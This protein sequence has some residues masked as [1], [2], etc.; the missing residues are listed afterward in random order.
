MARIV[1]VN[2]PNQQHAAI[3]LTAIYGIGRSRALMICA[4]AGVAIPTD[5]KLDGRSFLPQ[6]RG[7]KGQPRDWYYCWYAP[8]VKFI[9]E[10][11][12]NTRYKLYRGGEFYDLTKDPG[13]TQ[14]LPTGALTGEAAVAAKILQAALDRYKNARPADLPKPTGEGA[15]DN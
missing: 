1:G 3:A 15:G 8:R 9:G 6:L 2:I 13:E 4:A 14:P 11:A 12:A 10:F 7:E 5:W